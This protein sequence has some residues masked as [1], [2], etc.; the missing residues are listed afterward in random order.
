MRQK[1]DDFILA[2]RGENVARLAFSLSG[3]KELNVERVLRQVEGWQRLRRKVSSWAA[4]DE[5]EYPARLS[6]EQCSGEVAA[7]YKAA[8]VRR[9]CPVG[10]IMADLTGGFG[11]DFAFLAPHFER[12]LYVER[13]E[14][15]CRLARHNFP[16]LGLRNYEI[17]EGDGVKR[18]ACLGRLSFVMLDPAR[19]DAA[20]RKTVLL[21]DCEPNVIDLLPLL[22]E[23]A[24]IVLVKLS[25]ML[26]LGKALADLSCVAEVHVVAE[27]G[28]CKELL[29]VLRQ[30]ATSPTIYCVDNGRS[31]TFTLDEERSAVVEYT[32][33][34]DGF[35]CEPNAAVLKAGAFKSIALR[36]GLKKLH[37]NTHLY[38][39][40]H[41]IED[42]PGRV[43]KIREIIGFSKKELRAL[44]ALGQANLTV[45]NFPATVDELRKKLKLREG[46]ST[47]LFA[48]T[49]A[50]DRRLV[51]VCER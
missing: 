14:E 33:K 11:V 12:A 45:R 29:L 40:S 37:P 22:R 38:I 17:V 36:Y 48:T 24:Q 5:L 34:I 31:F 18:L 19:R 43:L 10:G 42:F 25:P 20:G 41:F 1:E 44:S 51:V 28:E 26:D 49:A 46:G 16:L 3:D 23:K 13:S 4:I 35:L 8:I 2:H 7:V 47:Y 50:G 30:D 21:E 6:L 32:D 39:S 9:L 15:L 27:G